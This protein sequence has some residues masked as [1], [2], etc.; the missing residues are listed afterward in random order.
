MQSI[1][2]ADS[3]VTEDDSNT[4]TH[5]YTWTHSYADVYWS[6][7]EPGRAELGPDTSAFPVSPFI[8]TH[9]DLRIKFV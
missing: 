9:G 7:R 8:Q 4:G 3:V 1:A 6:G 5:K 2:A